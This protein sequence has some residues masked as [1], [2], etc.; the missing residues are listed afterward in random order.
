MLLNATAFA[1]PLSN[2]SVHCIVTS[3]PY[4]GL[5]KYSG[6]PPMVFPPGGGKGG[7]PKCKHEWGAEKIEN[8]AGGKA[9]G[10]TGS[11]TNLGE[12]VPRIAKTVSQGQF[13]RCSA[14]LGDFGLEPT[15]ELYIEH[16]M[17]VLDECWRVLRKDGTCWWNLGDSY[18][19]VGTHHGSNNPGISQSAKRQQAE[20]T[21]K[22]PSLKPKDLCLVPHRFVLAAQA[23]GWWIRSDIIW[24]KPNPMPES[25]TD[26]PTDAYEHIFLM[27]KAKH[28]W[29]DAEAVREKVQP[30]SLI[31]A[32]SGWNPTQVKDG[33][34]NEGEPTD[35][36]GERWVNPSGRNLRNV[37]NF[38]TE[39]FPAYLRDTG[40]HFAQFPEEL[41]RRCVLAGCPE[42]TCAKCGAGYIRCYSMK[43]EYL[44][45]DEKMQVVQNRETLIGISS[46]GASE[47]RPSPDL[48]SMRGAS[49]EA[50]VPAKGGA[51]SSK[52]KAEI[53]PG[54]GEE[55]R[56]EE[57][58]ANRGREKENAGGGT[59]I[60]ANAERQ[61][62][63]QRT[64]SPVV[65]NR[66]RKNQRKDSM[67]PQAGIIV[68]SEG[69]VHG[70]GLDG[71]TSKSEESL[72]LLQKE[73][74]ENENSSDRPRNPVDEE[75]ETR[76]VEHSGL[77]QAVQLEEMEQPSGSRVTL[78][79]KPSC[80]CGTEETGKGVVLD[81]FSGSGTVC[82]VA[83]RSGRI[84]IGIELS[85]EYIKL[86]MKR[87]E[88]SRKQGVLI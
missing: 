44:A 29:Y 81:P 66:K 46:G 2:E 85:R 12:D 88:N 52:A 59:A 61:K 47:G 71:D 48:S 50:S 72:P 33:F 5:R 40:S 37:W 75:R 53:L 70:E 43:N 30:E 63:E 45:E 78:G 60:Q 18:N 9:H 84:G 4:W 31:R 69:S 56:T 21:T 1:L 74:Y 41:P 38:A 80:E 51:I 11:W 10:E 55:S 82:D 27:T 7:D 8:I 13:C 39:A 77:L 49:S 16:S 87:T 3:P 76:Q 25:C 26:R 83:V 22:E 20:W 15:I 34:R 23:R 28:Y 32:E 58:L 64:D 67:R 19:G 57:N 42:K 68:E 24:A 62:D 73:I 36:M 86:A 79:W 35:R 17:Q 14:W 6:L 54:L 65:K